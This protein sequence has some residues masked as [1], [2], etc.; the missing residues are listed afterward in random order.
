MST[1]GK[2]RRWGSSEKLGIVLAGMQ[3]DVEVSDL[4]RRDGIN[5][6]QSYAWKKQLLR[7]AIRVFEDRRGRPNLPDVPFWLTHY[8]TGLLLGPSRALLSS[9]SVCTAAVT[10]LTTAK[11]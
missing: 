3:G 7:S 2:R 5:P 6:V 11:T 1:N 10:T 9:R 8:I 4:C